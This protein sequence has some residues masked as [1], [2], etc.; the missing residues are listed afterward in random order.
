MNTPTPKRPALRY[1][2]GKWKLAP[3][4]ISHFPQHRVYTETYGGGASV[5]LRKPRCYAEIYNDLDGEIVNVFRVLRDPA[6]ARELERLITLTPYARTEFETSNL[7]SGDPIEQARR[8]IFRSF[9][10]HGST[11]TGKHG[12]GFRV[13]CGDHRRGATPA[14]EWKGYADHVATLAQRMAGVYIEQR[15]ALDVLTEYDGTKVLHYVDPPYVVDTRGERNAG[16]AYRHEMTDD[17]HRAMAAILHSL[18]GF[19]ILSGYACDLY[20]QELFADWHRVERRALADRSLERTEVL[21]LNPRAAQTAQ[22]RMEVA[23]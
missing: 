15:P 22:L 14:G 11:L 20:D 6:Q 9:A 17:D 18:K 10:G 19:V 4:I 12:T 5:L 7:A 2:G 1:H 3:W 21:W 8:T 13:Y 16:K 23:A